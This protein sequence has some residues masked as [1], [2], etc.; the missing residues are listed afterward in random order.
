MLGRYLLIHTVAGRGQVSFGSELVDNSVA[1]LEGGD[2]VLQQYIEFTISTALGFGEAE[3]RPYET[4]YA[5]AGPEKTSLSTPIE[6][7]GIEEVWLAEGQH[8]TFRETLGRT[9]MTELT[10]PIKL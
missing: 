6:F 3:I 1:K 9:M 5:E 4:E 7:L 10:M 8:V 2:A